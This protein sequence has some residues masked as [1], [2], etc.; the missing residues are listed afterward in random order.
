[1]MEYEFNPDE[2]G[3][4]YL[5][6]VEITTVDGGEVPN[7]DFENQYFSLDELLALEAAYS[8]LM[9]PW[10]REITD[11]SLTP[12]SETE[13]GEPLVSTG[14]GLWF[15]L[16]DTVQLDAEGMELEVTY[17]PSR[18]LRLSMNVT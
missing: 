4:G 10:V 1:E 16:G 15:T 13:D 14:N 3:N 8:E 9:N 7:P 12:G 17:N 5:D 2:N 18:N 11:L 6:I